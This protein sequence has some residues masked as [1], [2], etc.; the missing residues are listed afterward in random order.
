MGRRKK[1]PKS[2]HRENIASAANILFMEKGVA[3][4][5][6]DEVAKKAGYSKATLYVYF[7][8]KEEIFFFLVYNHM[9]NLYE[10]IENVAESK[11]DSEK[12]WIDNYIKICFSIEKLCKEHPLY[13]EGMTGSINVDI[14]SDKTPDIY[15]DIYNLGLHIN[16]SV[17]TII[18]NGIE[19]GYLKQDINCDAVTLFLWSS[20]SGIVHMAECK[21]DYY[22]MMNL[23]NDEFLKYQFL[24]LINCCK[25]I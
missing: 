6:M 8:N 21:K 1:K 24:L 20:I 9:K 19:I 3:E 18:N 2:V 25:N 17:K 4:T 7:E 10:T 5:T 15:K 14:N 22:K 16:K 13:F 23:D 12:Q 11:A